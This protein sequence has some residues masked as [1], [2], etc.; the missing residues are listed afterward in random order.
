MVERE[1]IPNWF[2]TARAWYSRPYLFRLAA[3]YRML[4]SEFKFSR[5]KA[6]SLAKK[7]AR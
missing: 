5:S 3:A 6:W 1:L 4:R 2:E 7:A